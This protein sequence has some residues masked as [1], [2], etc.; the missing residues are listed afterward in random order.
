MWQSWKIRP[1][2]YLFWLFHIDSTNWWLMVHTRLLIN[3]VLACFQHSITLLVS[4]LLDKA[5][6][7]TFCMKAANVSLCLVLSFSV[8]IADAPTRKLFPGRC[9]LP[10]STWGNKQ[11]SPR[12]MPHFLNKETMLRVD[13]VDCRL[14]LNESMQLGVLVDEL[15][16]WFEIAL[17]PM[18]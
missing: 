12:G 13:F 16:N 1:F 10:L 3:S 9:P 5:S 7:T 17:R 11:T 15:M 14:V 4:T 8:T 2:D 6:S 18:T